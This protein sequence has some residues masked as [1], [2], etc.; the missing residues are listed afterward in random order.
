MRNGMQLRGNCEDL[1]CGSHT[2]S[3]ALLHEISLLGYKINSCSESTQIHFKGEKC[4][5]YSVFKYYLQIF[6]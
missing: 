3:L 4:K 2:F 6:K 5:H 1:G